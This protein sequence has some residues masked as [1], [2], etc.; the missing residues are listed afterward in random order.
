MIQ[1]QNKNVTV[2]QS[3]LVQTTSTV[4]TTDDFVLIV[5]PN[6]LPHE[7]KEIQ[8]Y[9]AMVQRGKPLY[10]LFTHGD[11][12]HIIGYGAFPEALIIGSTGLVHHPK[13]KEKVE[14]I[15]EFDHEHYIERP[16]ETSFPEVNH[17][18]KADGQ[19]LLIGGTTLTFYLAPGHTHDGLF[20]I[21]EDL[22]VWIAGDYLSDFELPFIYHSPSA[23][24]ETLQK[25]RQ[26]RD[27]HTTLLL[28]PGHGKVTEKG[29]EIERRIRLAESYLNRLIEA[30]LET[31][32]KA[33]EGLE[34]E[35]RFP[36]S[37]TKQC[38]DDNVAIV[39]RDFLKVT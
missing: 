5:D 13:K 14:L 22:G 23:Y 15:R 2:F 1:Y 16:Y 9:V 35:M 28:I 19:T 36:S 26:I 37:F 32:T 24:K 8:E 18:I 6:W 38:H 12:D 33:I 30:V 7:I 3:A 20:T 11:F 4:V 29:I 31:D 17:E 21:I 27:Q 39:K 34:K 10:L 25:A